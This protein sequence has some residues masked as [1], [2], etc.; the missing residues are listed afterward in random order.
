VG[1]GV[2]EVDEKGFL[3]F[4]AFLDKPDTFISDS[5]GNGSLIERKF[6]AFLITHAL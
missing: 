5:P 1:H 2:G 4:H 6:N 3:F